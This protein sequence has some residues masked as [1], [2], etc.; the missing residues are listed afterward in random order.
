YGDI[1]GRYQRQP[2]PKSLDPDGA[3]CHGDSAGLLQRRPVRAALPFYVGKESNNLEERRAGLIHK[4][5]ETVGTYQDPR[6]NLW[7][8]LV[9]PVLRDFPAAEVARRSGL[10]RRTIERHVAG[11]S[12]PHRRHEAVLVALAL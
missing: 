7:T 2:E 8:E 5:D 4:L 3:V 10:H 6:G 1:V 11:T 9:L 12:A